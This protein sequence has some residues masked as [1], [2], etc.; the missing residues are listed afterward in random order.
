MSGMAH[1]KW[2][3]IILQAM[4]QPL[5]YLGTAM[6]VLGSV[7]NIAGYEIAVRD[8]IWPVLVG[9]GVFLLLVAVALMFMDRKTFQT[10]IDVDAIGIAITFPRHHDP[11]SVPHNVVGTYKNWPTSC[12]LWLFSLRD[13]RYRPIEKIRKDSP[14]DWS[15]RFM[16]YNVSPG[17]RVRIGIF[18]L[19]LGG[20]AQ[21]YTYLNTV[22]VIKR[23]APHEPWPGMEKIG[24]DTVICAET[25]VIIQ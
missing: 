20:Q 14:S 1:N 7:T 4:K 5:L 18:A 6:I 25:T 19:G 17:Q 12:E 13:D 15:A 2:L 23:L 3:E 9:V 16:T 8:I 21:L 24:P 11:V 10:V 22:D